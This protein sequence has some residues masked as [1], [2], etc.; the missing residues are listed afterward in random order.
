M[1]YLALACDYDG[2]IALNGRVVPST[3]AAL[4]SLRGSG[5]K[6]IL[7]TGREL[8]ELLGIFPEI[9]LFERVVAE[10]GALLYNPA[11]RETKLLAEKPSDQFVLTLQAKG[12][13]PMSVGRSIVATW[14]PHETV[15]LETIRDMG[16]ELQVIFN[17]DAVMILPAGVNKASGLLAALKEMGLSPHEVVAVGDAENDHAFFALCECSAAVD[18]ALPTVKERADMVTPLDHG[19]GVEQLIARMIESDLAEMEP[20]LV[21]HHLLLGHADSGAEVRLPSYRN[22]LLIAG[23]SASGKSTVAKSFLERLQEQRYQY[24]IIDPEG[25]YDG[26]EGAVTLGNGKSG[27]TADEVLQLLKKPSNNVVVNLVGLPLADRPRFFLSLM[28]SLLEMRARTGR[29]HWIVVDE[30]HHLLPTAWEPGKS[31]A[32]KELDRMVFITVHPEQILASALEMVDTVAAVG[33]APE[34]TIGRFCQAIQKPAPAN[35]ESIA[36]AGSKDGPNRIILW[37]RRTDKPPVAVRIIPAKAEH[38]RHVRKYA[39]GTLPDER[40]FYFR[41]PHG[42]LNLKAQNLML[43]IQIAEGVD[44]ETWLFHLQAGDYSQWFRKDIHDD[45]LADA[46]STIEKSPNPSP[47]TTRQ[48]MRELIEQHYTVPASAPIPLPGTAAERP[49]K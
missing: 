38:H 12:V 8:D 26:L 34:E 2:T 49:V 1:R 15:V 5:R 36:K 30:T 27:P 10:N 11:T 6:L 32:T 31:V 28:P 41:G 16:L 20:K 25:D 40:C 22:N 23:P 14:K 29:P 7:V 43:F 47:A 18:N 35:A 46:A 24:C 9:H 45:R 19:F 48:K 17:K 33:A 37:S 4:E 21:R 42:K 3:V 44:D 13:R 39:E